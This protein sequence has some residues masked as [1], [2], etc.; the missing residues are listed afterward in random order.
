MRAVTASRA[1]ANSVTINK[2]KIVVRI[3]PKI[4]KINNYLVTLKNKPVL[5][6]KKLT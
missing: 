4:K 2:G 3:K 1:N 5:K 6:E